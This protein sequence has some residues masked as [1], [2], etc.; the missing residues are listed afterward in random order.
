VYHRATRP[1]VV[2][3][4]GTKTRISGSLV[5]EEAVEAMVEASKSFVRVSDLQARASERIAAVTGAEAGY[6]TAGASA[7]LLLGAAA[8][9]A[10]DDLDAMYQLPD[11]DGLADEIVVPRTHRTGYDHA[12][13]A[14]GATL[15][16]VAHDHGVPVIVD[17]A[18]EV[19]PASNLSRFVD[20][21][22]DL[23]AFSGGKAIRGPQTTGILAGR[24]ALIE[25]VAFQQLDMHANDAVWDPPTDLVDVD[26]YDGVPRQGIGRS[27]KVG[28]EELAGLVTAL[29]LFV[30]EDHAALAQEWTERAARIAD[31]LS[32]E[33]ARL[34]RG[35]QPRRRRLHRQPDVSDRR[36]G[37]VRRRA[38]PLVP[39]S[40]RG[41]RRSR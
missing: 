5:R 6:V 4:A 19:P 2:N 3:A 35:R 41:R 29:D 33:P 23:V 14:A 32:A 30:E 10:G 24:A 8:C 36:A 31:D 15:V 9:I 25:S 16:D 40:V 7:G 26:R 34:R 38:D 27:L 12:L 13:R 18:A 20:Q 1:T 11:T 22:A 39:V 21:G 28:K 17:A 37:D